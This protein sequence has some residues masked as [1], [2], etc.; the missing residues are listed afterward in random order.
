MFFKQG[1]K[2]SFFIGLINLDSNHIEKLSQ[3]NNESF[4]FNENTLI[5]SC[6]DS[7]YCE[8]DLSYEVSNDYLLY[9]EIK[10]LSKKWTTW[11]QRWTKW[12]QKWMINLRY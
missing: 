11:K 10:N 1:E 8:I 9:K 2:P 4:D 6:I 5:I 7:E 12:K 3:Y